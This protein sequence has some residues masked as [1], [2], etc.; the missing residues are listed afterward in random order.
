MYINKLLLKEFGKF[1]NKE[2]RL[3]KGLNLIY[4]ANESGKTT[5]KEF[6]VGMLYGI[7][8]TRGIGARLDNYELRKP[9]N[10]GGYSG[11]AYAVTDEKSYLLERN[12]LRTSKNATLTEIDTGK[13]VQLKNQ[14][15]YK[16][17]LFDVDKSTYINTLC[18]GEHG[19]APGKELAEDLGN[20]VVN[21]TT[22]RCRY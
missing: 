1:N 8:K 12:F 17:I 19:A 16:G 18:I 13:E 3:K 11:K 7:D 9:V 14:N 10:G 22:T 20:Y 4:G 15:S 6:I 2:I 21:L 5:V